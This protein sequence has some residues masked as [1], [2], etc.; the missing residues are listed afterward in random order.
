MA[1]NHIELRAWL[2][3]GYKFD[4][5]RA[6]EAYNFIMGEN[7]YE[8]SVV[9]LPG[10]YLVD[11]CRNVELFTGSG[12]A[13]DEKWTRVGVV[14]HMGSFMIEPRDAKKE[15]LDELTKP[16]RGE[17][18]VN[19]LWGNIGDYLKGNVEGTIVSREALKYGLY[20]PSMGQLYDIML[21]R[22]YINKAMKAIG[23][24]PLEGVY[25]SSSGSGETSLW[26]LNLNNGYPSDL[27]TSCADPKVRLC[28]KLF[29]Y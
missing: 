25:W 17:N 14:G 15:C 2:L 11:E 28:S 3:E 29:E 20:V 7:C 4:M 5:N 1:G 6:M 12:K 16:I 26:A 27:S 24:E 8:P 23:G 21:M 22:E 19:V 9:H 10:V 18:F 13:V